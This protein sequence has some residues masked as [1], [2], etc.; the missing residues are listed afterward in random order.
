MENIL[1]SLHFL[2][3]YFQLRSTREILHSLTTKSLKTQTEVG[4]QTDFPAAMLE[5]YVVKNRRRILS[6]LGFHRAATQISSDRECDSSSLHS[7]WHPFP[8][9]DQSGQRQV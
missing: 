8:N 6:L 7:S 2:H 9:Q 1:I 3:K 4:V 5:E